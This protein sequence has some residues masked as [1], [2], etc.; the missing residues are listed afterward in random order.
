MHEQRIWTSS[1]LDFAKL[2]CRELQ[3]PYLGGACWSLLTVGKE[4]YSVYAL[5]GRTAAQSDGTVLTIAKRL[6]SP[7]YCDVFAM[8]HAHRCV[9]GIGLTQY[10]DLRSKAVKEQRKIVV[11]TG[12]YLDY[13]GYWQEKGGEISKI[14]S[15]KI[16]FF[17]NNHQVHISW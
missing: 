9:D 14:G 12:S 3:I 13:G 16:K 8:A 4:H 5:H 15:P 17:L 1:G 2:I 6:A 11:V 7:F 10:V